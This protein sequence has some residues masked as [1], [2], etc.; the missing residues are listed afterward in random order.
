MPTFATQVTDYTSQD[1]FFYLKITGLPYYIFGRIDPTSSTYGASA[2]TLPT[3][4]SAVRGLMLP[5]DT[6]E[7]KLPDIIGGI[8]S[9]PR[10]RLGLLDFPDT[11]SSGDVS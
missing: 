2:W 4:F 10:M 9:A 8:A 5:D 3:G 1:Q 7:Q 11:R 6:M